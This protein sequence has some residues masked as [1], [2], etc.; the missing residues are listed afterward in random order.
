MD[1]DP[2]KSIL[3]YLVSQ[4][5][6]V[7]IVAEWT[8]V[9]K[10]K[11]DLW[12][13]DRECHFYAGESYSL[14]GAICNQ[15]IKDVDSLITLF[16]ALTI[17]SF[18][19]GLLTF[20]ELNWFNFSSQRRLTTLSLAFLGFS[21]TAVNFFMWHFYPRPLYDNRDY[22]TLWSVGSAFQL[23]S[24]MLFLVIVTLELL[25]SG[26]YDTYKSPPRHIAQDP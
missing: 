22:I 8:W 4:F 24:A 7:S 1:I 11:D 21:C 6:L 3:A 23:A 14:W 18:F 12:G 13:G 16:R 19:L 20:I 10:S 9:T 25:Y 5:T 2:V 26:R 15:D 17:T